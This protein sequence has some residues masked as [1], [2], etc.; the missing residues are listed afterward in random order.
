MNK[1]LSLCLKLL[2]AALMVG[3]IAWAIWEPGFEPALAALSGLVGFIS[4]FIVERSKAKPPT[5]RQH[6]GKGSTNYQA[7]GDMTINSNK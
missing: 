3:G 5:M 1:A 2:T 6:G 7:G 4:L